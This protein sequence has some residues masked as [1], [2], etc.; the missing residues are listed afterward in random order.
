MVSLRHAPLR[1]RRVQSLRAFRRTNPECLCIGALVIWCLGCCCLH[2]PSTKMANIDLKMGCRWLQEALTK[3]GGGGVRPSRRILGTL[4]GPSWAHLGL[5]WAFL[6]PSWGSKG[7]FGG[8]SWAQ[9]GGGWH[10]MWFKGLLGE[11]SGPLGRSWGPCWANLGPVLG[12]LGPSLVLLGGSTGA[13]GGQ[14]WAQEGGGR[15]EM[16]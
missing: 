3:S 6:G 15:H 13:S 8:Q 4:L 2:C 10:K 14:S 7:A 9:E 12:C 5:S 11:G 16:W 1:G